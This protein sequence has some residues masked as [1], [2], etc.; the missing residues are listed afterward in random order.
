MR[1]LD[2]MVRYPSTGGTPRALDRPLS[3]AIGEG[4]GRAIVRGPAEHEHGVAAPEPGGALDGIAHRDIARL[5]RHIE[6]EHLVELVDVDARVDALL[7]QRADNGDALDGARAAEEVANHGFG[8]RN[9]DA[10]EPLP[11]HPL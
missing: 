10:G 9:G 11:E 6:R 2:D 7:A 3:S 4:P 1:I 8:G 5:A